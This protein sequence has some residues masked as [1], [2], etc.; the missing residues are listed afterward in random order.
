MQ[1]SRRGN[2]SLMMGGLL[3]VVVG[4]AAFA[5]DLAL[6]TMA[7]L[8][9]QATSDAAAHA[10]LVAFRQSH[11]RS[12]GDAAAAFIVSANRVAMGT[13]MIDPGYPQYGTYDFVV[14]AFDPEDDPEIANAVRVRL[15]RSDENAVEMVL[16]SI[17]GYPRHDV[18][19]EAVSATQE[20]AIMLVQDMS[21]SMMAAGEDSAVNLSRLANRSFLDFLHENTQVGDRIGLA[22]FAQFGVVEPITA[23]PW[24]T[25]DPLDRPWAPLLSVQQDFE[26]LAE[27][28]DG[29][30]N[31]ADGQPCVLTGAPHP[32]ADDIGQCT[33]P[34]IAVE[35]ALNEILAETDPSFLRGIVFM[36]DGLPN[37][38]ADGPDA[39]AA[40]RLRDVIGAACV[41]G[42]HV[43]SVVYHN[44]SFDAGLMDD[45]D[46]GFGFSRVTPDAADLAAM[47][48]EIARSLP[49]VIVN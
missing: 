41:N 5:V 7:N 1:R 4:F 30:C 33:N 6:I 34:A 43:W 9:I 42:I 21:C 16:A 18:R 3:F 15:S 26:V 49:L 12:D 29:I 37:C 40:Q 23:P 46:C 19:A 31:T 36:S 11:Q 10:A 25:D 27:R 20:R 2:Y 24:R 38:S 35:Q 28:I 13:A 22:M 44:G 45:L 39:E 8:Q 14:R 32:T 48:Q 17:L 47:Y